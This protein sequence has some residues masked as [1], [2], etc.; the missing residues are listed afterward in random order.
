MNSEDTHRNRDWNQ[1]LMLKSNG[2]IGEGEVK[3]RQKMNEVMRKLLLCNCYDDRLSSYERFKRLLITV[4]PT[5]SNIL[6]IH[7][8][9][10]QNTLILSFHLFYVTAV[11]LYITIIDGALN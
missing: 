6:R 7:K 9:N 2:Y 11:T 8:K 1:S 5:H 10:A 3:Q 4:L